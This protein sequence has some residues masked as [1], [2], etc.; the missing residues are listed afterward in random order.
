MTNMVFFP[1][2]PWEGSLLAGLSQCSCSC[3]SLWFLNSACGPSLDSQ[4]GSDNSKVTGSPLIGELYACLCSC[5]FCD[6]P[7]CSTYGLFFGNFYNQIYPQ[8]RLP[9]TQTVKNLPARQETRVQ[10]LSW[11]VPLEKGMAIHCSILVWRIPWT[12]KPGRLQSV[13]LQGQTQLSD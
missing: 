9:V 7:H 4:T 12:E 10:S 8:N 13:G 6:L 2:S 5:S 1:F 3:P 11:K